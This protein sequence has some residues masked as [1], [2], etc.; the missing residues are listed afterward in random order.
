MKRER[1]GG[2]KVFLR[3]GRR[4]SFPDTDYKLF[5]K[6]RTSFPCFKPAGYTT[7]DRAR[8]TK[9]IFYLVKHKEK[10]LPKIH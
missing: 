9:N 5:S 1:R 7:K 4:K 8:E 2:E 10:H 3:S 6:P